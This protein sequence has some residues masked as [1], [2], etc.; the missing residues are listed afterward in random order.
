MS[1]IKGEVIL[2][3]H[4]PGVV[5]HEPS[6]PFLT[7]R[8]ELQQ[9]PYDQYQALTGG[10]HDRK[11]EY[12]QGA[13]VVL[14]SATQTTLVPG[15]SQGGTGFLELKCPAHNLDLL[16]TLPNG[17][18]VAWALDMIYAA[19]ASLSLA[20]PLSGFI[21]PRVSSFFLVPDGN[22]Q[23]SFRDGVCDGIQ[24]QGDADHEYFLASRLTEAPL[25]RADIQHANRSADLIR[26]I[27]ESPALAGALETFL[28]AQDAA[29]GRVEQATLCI[30]ALEELF[31]RGQT[32]GL[33]K[34]FVATSSA[35]APQGAAV[36]KRALRDLYD[37]R[38]GMLHGRTGDV[39]AVSPHTLALAPQLLA[40]AILSLAGAVSEGAD[41][42]TL[43][44]EG[45]MALSRIAQQ[46]PWQPPDQFRRDN[47]M[48]G[49]RSSTVS[50]MGA[51]M[52]GPEG[53][54]IAWS[55]LIGLDC[56]TG[57]FRIG[58]TVPVV[59]GP[60]SYFKL[61]ELEDREIREDF[62]RRTSAA[63]QLGQMPDTGRAL[64]LVPDASNDATGMRLRAP[65]DY[66]GVRAAVIALRT[67]GFGT[68]L[69]P[70]LLG[71]Y[72]FEGNIRLRLP[73]V[74]RQTLLTHW[75]DEADRPDAAALS[76]AS[77]LA[78]TVLRIARDHPGIDRQFTLL[79]EAFFH[80]IISNP[81]RARLCFAFCDAVIGRFSGPD[82]GAQVAHLSQ[83]IAPGITGTWF[84]EEA[85]GLRNRLAHTSAHDV[86]KAELNQLL[87]FSQQL[88]LRLLRYWAGT[89]GDVSIKGFRADIK[90]EL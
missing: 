88:A 57:T 26:L 45:P 14:V 73:S 35:L 18:A 60:L 24:V 65:C 50:Q 77:S 2:I 68:F 81:V 38:S 72:Y 22:T 7:A 41:L 33:Q 58:E 27:Q 42:D 17:D 55:P 70:V 80:P 13:P 30:I 10:A 76:K 5:I 89:D 84:A 61:E 6:I 31:L 47:R 12:E 56:P 37:L 9:L 71:E 20:R 85:R 34:A 54:A 62:L 53:Q 32:S 83:K 67:L 79:R 44:D 48:S 69:D 1:H 36:S 40:N 29:L 23:F 82:I 87:A 86:P 39:A 49:H 52:G 66:P 15:K 3:A 90:E 75:I 28:A 64:L 19:W 8:T 4:L 63:I 59:L 51:T 21:Q 43:L 78:D 46:D 25:S 74:F 16:A 11:S